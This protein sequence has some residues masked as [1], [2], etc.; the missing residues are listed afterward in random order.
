MPGYIYINHLREFR[1]SNVDVYKIG[2]TTDITR[3]MGQYPK[4]SVM[5]ASCYVDNEA[6]VEEKLKRVFRENSNPRKDYGVEYFEVDPQTAVKLFY[7]CA[8]EHV[9]KR[10]TVD[11]SVQYTDS[12]VAIDQF[13]RSLRQDLSGKI[14]KSL[15][16]YEDYNS[17]SQGKCSKGITHATFIRTLKEFTGSST[18]PYRFDDGIHQAIFFPNLTDAVEKDCLQ[19]FL[20]TRLIQTN[21]QSDTIKRADAYRAYVGVCKLMKSTP[22]NKHD[23]LV[24]MER[25][26]GACIAKSGDNRMFWRGWILRE[27]EQGTSSTNVDVKDNPIF[28]WL[29]EHVKITNNIKERIPVDGLLELISKDTGITWT[30]MKVCKLLSQFGYKSRVSNGVRYYMG[31]KYE[32]QRDSE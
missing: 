27:S 26:M 10:N 25:K 18:K 24:W 1:Q 19:V 14:V 2:R 22:I 7:E 8:F 28:K 4:G 30:K 31:I 17:W 16:L 23:F 5:I 3:R 12:S 13:L 9:G 11:V 20:S 21:K 6:I 29:A 32:P 15:Q